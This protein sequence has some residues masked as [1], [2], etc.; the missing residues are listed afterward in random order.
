M[1]AIGSEVSGASFLAT[2]AL[3]SV[4]PHRRS[5]G[6]CFPKV[7]EGLPS[8]KAGR[9]YSQAVYCLHFI[10]LL[11]AHLNA[12]VCPRAGGTQAALRTLISPEYLSS[13]LTGLKFVASHHL[14]KAT[15]EA[16]HRRCSLPMAK[17]RREL[18]CSTRF[19]LTLEF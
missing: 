7:L 9:L 19:F 4:A 11:G 13:L 8:R 17:S 18:T 1:S 10:S 5:M 14:Q 15:G 16:L 6:C 3:G 12:D 2:E